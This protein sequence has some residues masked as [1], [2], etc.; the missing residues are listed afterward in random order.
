M[1]AYTN[2]YANIANIYDK[3]YCGDSRVRKQKLTP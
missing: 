1:S 2:T 3:R